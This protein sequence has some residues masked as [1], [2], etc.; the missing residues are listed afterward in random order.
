M[1]R[2]P[3]GLR[4]LIDWLLQAKLCVRFGDSVSELRQHGIRIIT[5]LEGLENT[6]LEQLA[7]ETTHLFPGLQRA[8]HA[9]ET[10]P[11]IRRL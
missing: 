11:N 5:V 7:K 3:Y 8:A 1:L 6:Y 9:T 2:S 10:D 4:E